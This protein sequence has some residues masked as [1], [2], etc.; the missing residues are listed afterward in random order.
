MQQTFYIDSDEEISSVIER[1]RKSL[2]AEN[3]F[4]LP[5]RALV[6][7]SIVNLKLLRREADK[8]KKSVVIVT[9]DE[10]S[11]NMATRAGLPV[12]S[13]MEGL[14]PAVIG[15]D[16]S[17]SVLIPQSLATGLAM[18]GGMINE[19]KGH[20][21]GVGSDDFY[22]GNKS[23]YSIL[24][25]YQTESNKRSHAESSA[26]T[27]GAK[28][29]RTS[30]SDGIL[31]VPIR[32][33]A[34]VEQP[35]KAQSK[36]MP[37]NGLD[38][39]K[40]KALERMFQD[41]GKTS[42]N[43]NQK[44]VTEQEI[45]VKGRVK[46]IMA[47]FIF[48]CV[49]AFAG[50]AAYLLVPKA[51]IVVTLFSQKRKIDLEVTGTE[52][53]D[54][55]NPA[56]GQLAVK[57]FHE[58]QKISLP[59]EATGQNNVAG[60]KAHGTIVVYNEFS[61][62]PQTLVATTRFEAA[63]GKIFRLLKNVVVPGTTQVEG[64][65]KPGVIEVEVV[66]DGTGSEYEIAPTDFTIPGFKDSPKFEKFSAKSTEAM[67]S[68]SATGTSVKVVT[69]RDIENAKQEAETKLKEKSKE[70]LLS[71]V[72]Q[73][74]LLLEE[75]IQLTSVRSVAS[76][77]VGD[78]QDSFNYDL[79]YEINAV[80]FSPEAAKALLVAQYKKEEKNVNEIENIKVDYAALTPDFEQKTMTMK[81]HGEI[82]LKGVLE[83]E[84]LKREFLGK[85]ET[86]VEQIIKKYPQI[87]NIT[88]EFEPKFVSRVPQ[89]AGRVS[90]E[91]KAEN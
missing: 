86:E 5:K 69:L 71:K 1:L 90:L 85:N 37:L 70:L 40:E 77:K 8:M 56:S 16:D 44:D 26:K 48:L 17:G 64:E 39:Q 78:V 74:E 52:S 82:L 73:D 47:A 12:R 79:E 18:D 51:D 55:A 10:L 33:S 31:N 83:S 30:S 6:L 50:I 4:V 81:L 58:S 76:A 2:A 19:G 91:I 20:L 7:Q 62:D 63:D 14:E 24:S 66:A 38:S 43:K 46:K 75:A 45:P 11:A 28:R 89:Y 88:F 65:T 59:H 29:N 53:S 32:N 25:G 9:Q 60:A 3:F 22:E 21:K 68:G 49:V 13:S 34:K 36:V 54:T 15:E 61:P 23:D 84:Q 41:T 72:S 35:R 80:A 27:E 42:N 87:K 67:V 57:F